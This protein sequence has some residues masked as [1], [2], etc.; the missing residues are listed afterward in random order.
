MLGFLNVLLINLGQTIDIVMV[1]LDAEVLCQI[2]NLHVLRD[3]V[4]LKECLTL[5]MSEAE[6]YDVDL[7]ERHC[8]SK[9]QLGFPEQSLVY[10]ADQIT[11]IAL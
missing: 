7:V 10:V 8:V 4:L 6:E 5:T 9:A 11:C 2:D 1:A 3:S